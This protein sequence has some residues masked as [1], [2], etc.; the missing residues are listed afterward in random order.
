MAEKK[1]TRNSTPAAKKSTRS[2]KPQAIDENRASETVS[3]AEA[4]IATARNAVIEGNAAIDL[5]AVRQRAYE[6]YEERGGQ[7]GL[8]EDDWYRAEQEIRA[9][10][11]RNQQQIPPQK[12]S[13]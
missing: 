6:L 1:Q 4:T 8:H 5:D 3:T 2:A 10:H 11:N 9:R 7:H 13:A 12:K